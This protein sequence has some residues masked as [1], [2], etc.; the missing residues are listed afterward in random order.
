MLPSHLQQRHQTLRIW[1]KNTGGSEEKWKFINL[2]FLPHRKLDH[3]TLILRI[4]PEMIWQCKCNVTGIC[5]HQLLL[6]GL[7]YQRDSV[8]WKRGTGEWR[9]TQSAFQAQVTPKGKV[10]RALVSTDHSSHS[11]HVKR[12]NIMEAIKNLGNLCQ[13][14]IHFLWLW[15]QIHLLLEV[16]WNG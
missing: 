5:L 16:L 13:S 15:E 14:H 4:N 6:S 3:L 2:E 7:F 12:R 1:N 9:C 8:W 11:A 10:V